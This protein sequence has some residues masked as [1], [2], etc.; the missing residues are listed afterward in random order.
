MASDNLSRLEHEGFSVASNQK[1]AAAFVIDDLLIS[2]LLVIVFWDK[3]AG[4]TNIEEVIMFINQLLFEVMFVKFAYHTFFYYQYGA[5][6]GKIVMR[7]RVIELG[8]F[9]SP[10]LLTSM[11]RSGVRLVSEFFFYFGFLFAFFDE[12]NQSLHDKL[13]RTV[14]VD[15]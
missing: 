4:A 1:R 13:A 7:V 14:V 11:N 10:D 12:I 2:L 15:A 5:T 3:I 9:T 8:R 6:I